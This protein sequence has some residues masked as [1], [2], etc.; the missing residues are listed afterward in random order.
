MRLDNISFL[1]QYHREIYDDIGNVKI[2]ENSNVTVITA[3]SGD[4]TAKFKKDDYDVYLH[5][6][7]DPIKESVRILNKY[8]Q[9]LVKYNYVIIFGLGLGYHVET[10]VKEFPNKNY[11][12]Y[13]PDMEIFKILLEVKDI[14]EIVQNIKHHLFVP[15][16]EIDK[17]RILDNI[18][19]S[20]DEEVLFIIHPSYEKI[21]K[22]EY[23]N[24]TFKF[25]QLL[26]KYKFN[27]IVNSTFQ[28]RWTLN[29]INNFKFTMKARSILSVSKN[30]PL[31][32]KPVIIV[33]A[34]PS[35]YDELILLKK[36]KSEGTAYLFAV[37]SA[38]KVLIKNGIEPD[39][40]CTYDPQGHN[41]KV[42]EE[43]IERN[44]EYIPMIYGTTVGYETLELYKGPKLFMVTSQD[45]LTPYF[46]DHKEFHIVEDAPSIAVITLQLLHYL[47]VSHIILV[48]QNLSYRDGEFYAKGI[49]YDSR[50][51]RVLEK[52][53]VNHLEVTSVTGQKLFT[54]E[55]FYRMKESIEYYIN[56][57]DM[58][59]V[60][61]TTA[62][63]AD[64]KNVPFTPLSVVKERYLKEP[65]VDKSWFD[66]FTILESIDLERK[67]DVLKTA[68][69][70]FGDIIEEIVETLR[71]IDLFKHSTSQKLE[72]LFIKLDKNTRRMDNNLFYK[73]FIHQIL[74]VER[75]RIEKASRKIKAINH[76]REKAP[77][78]IENFS[79]FI[80]SVKENE[81]YIETAYLALLNELE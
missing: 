60:I 61:N 25:K 75:A 36:I 63:G 53:L 21:F 29:S 30:N 39:A 3:K 32:G 44:I 50:S 56:K 81:Q 73:L 23:Q 65:V 15:G 52:D 77:K 58:K 45:I 22:E 33:A 17:D 28:K 7:Y 10:I 26:K 20:I 80:Q 78:I 47:G 64:I 12:L 67:L 9:D 71:K 31:K 57:W 11:Y 14:K 18:S 70:D 68:R 35:L 13:E 79:S 49:E 16:N 34:G 19:Q 40:V 1:K 38:N 41:Y 24:F 51:Q 55:G 62:E 74:R 76:A 4:P 42:F 43:M 46:Y 8:K 72:K 6:K 2:R 27:I 59:N 66:N 54:N 69:K 48:G 5:S 37:G